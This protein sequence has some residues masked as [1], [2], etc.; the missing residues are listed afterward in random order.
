[1]PIEQKESNLYLQA[2][3]ANTGGGSMV[4]IITSNQW[5]YVLVVNDEIVTAYKSEDDFFDG[6][7]AIAFT[8]INV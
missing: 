4:T 8:Y 1:M 7:E 3:E 5:S 2:N 6:G